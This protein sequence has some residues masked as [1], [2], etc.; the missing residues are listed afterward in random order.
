MVNMIASISSLDSIII[1]IG[2]AL[3]V[4][5][6]WFFFGG[7]KK[8][9]VAAKGD[10]QTQQIEI[11]VMGGYTPS[12]ISLAKDRPAKLVF[13]RQETSFCS[14]EVIL[15]AFKIRRNLPAFQKTTIEFTPEKFG[16]FEFTC[17]MGMLHGKIIVR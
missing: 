2:L 17:G 10:G 12:V 7:K 9:V 1:L 4:F 15:P 3:I 13:N 8:A 11:E 14:E 6:I 5:I 16:E